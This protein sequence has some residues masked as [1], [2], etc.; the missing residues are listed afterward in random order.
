MVRN[1]NTEI[2][3][4][5]Y[6]HTSPSGKV[7]I[8]ITSKKNAKVRWNYGSGYISCWYFKNAINKYGWNNIK[9]EILLEGVSESEAKY[10]EKY[11]IRWYKM[12]G[13]S[14]NLTDG[15]DGWLGH[16]HT[17]ES[18]YKMRI[19][20]LGRKLSNETKQ[21]MSEARKGKHRSKG[22]HHSE[23]ARKKMSEQRKGKKTVYYIS[24]EELSRR[25]KEAQKGVTCKPVLQYTING[26]FIQEFFSQSE[27][28][29]AVGAK[30]PWHIGDCCKGK[31]KSSNGYIWRYKDGQ[32]Y[33]ICE[34]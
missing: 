25:F 28:A 26:E 34:H 6:K 3:W 2:L 13:I 7:Y 5:V 27:A 29:R 8:G 10:A 20:K 31:I 30:S 15:G 19:A 23:E 9:H 22:W 14:Y 1:E 21:K 32:K 18:K 33:T 16:H 12:Q 4:Q 24:K 11:L 17:D